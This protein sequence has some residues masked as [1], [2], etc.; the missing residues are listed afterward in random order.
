M[1]LSSV[2]PYSLCHQKKSWTSSA[3]LRLLVYQGL[4]SESSG[5]LVFSFILHPPYQQPGSKVTDFIIQKEA[6]VL[7]ASILKNGHTVHCSTSP[8]A[9]LAAW[10]CIPLIL[11]HRWINCWKTKKSCCEEH[12]AGGM[13]CVPRSPAHVICQSVA[14]NYER[15]SKAM[16]ETWSH[17]FWLTQEFAFWWRKEARSLLVK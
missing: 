10:L 13:A 6:A 2:P 9:T 7:V 14:E 12:A 3:A 8:Q 17:G 5:Y 15:D 1:W 4:L 11:L 16:A